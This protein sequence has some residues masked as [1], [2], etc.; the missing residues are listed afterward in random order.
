VQ[1]IHS[2]GA[3]S[4]CNIDRGIDSIDGFLFPVLCITPLIFAGHLHQ[5]GKTAGSG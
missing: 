5:T 4:D 1:V 3:F 2:G